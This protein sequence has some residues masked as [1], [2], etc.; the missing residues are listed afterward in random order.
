[1]KPLIIII[2]AFAHSCASAAANINAHEIYVID[3]DTIRHEG[4]SIRLLGFNS[5]ETRQAKCESERKLGYE[6]K[7]NLRIKIDQAKTI[8]IQLKTKRDGSPKRDKYGRLLG[9]LYL[10]QKDA[11]QIQISQGFARP[12]NGGKRKSWCQ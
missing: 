5:P 4:E 8:S 2:I 3:G 7:E 10:D 12:Y 11:A 9:A 1:M 6:A